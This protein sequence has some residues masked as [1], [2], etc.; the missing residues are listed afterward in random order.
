M[1]TSAKIGGLVA[2]AMIAASGASLAADQVIPY[3]QS[4][5]GQVV[6]NSTGLCWRTG[7][8]TPALAEALGVN[9]A[10]CACD[11][12]I[13]DAAACK[14]VE[15]PAPVKAA[16]KV[17]FS[18]DML[19]N[20]N[21][22]DLK[23]E[24]KAVLDDLVSRIAGVDIEVILSTGYADR[25]GS[26][27]FNERLSLKRAEAVKTYLVSKGVDATLIQTE[28]KGEADPVVNCPNP[29]RKGQ[30]KNFREL[31]KCL[32]PNRRAVVEVVGTRPAE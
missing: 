16:E 15:E 6:V 29:S 32:A 5:S 22:S 13:L 31:V 12:D 11:A 24:G 7:F 3:V 14:A 10:G 26:D 8:W 17:T 30:I 25:I 9:G 28:G 27:K 18:A 20:Y 23:D 21:R 19:F 2:A 1:K 4:S